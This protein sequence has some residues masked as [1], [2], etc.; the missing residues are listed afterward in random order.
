MTEFSP[1][2]KKKLQY[3]PPKKAGKKKQVMAT[4]K[5]LR[6]RP[7]KYHFLIPPNTPDAVRIELEQRQKPVSLITNIKID[8]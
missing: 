5:I 7:A 6:A 1:E 8:E 4:K 2:R 3:E